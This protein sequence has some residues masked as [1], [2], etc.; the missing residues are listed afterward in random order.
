MT[1]Q[2][3]YMIQFSTGMDIAL[4][5]DLH[6]PTCR[7]HHLHLFC[8][9]VGDMRDPSHSHSLPTP[10]LSYSPKEMPHFSAH[11]DKDNKPFD[12]PGVLFL[13]LRVW[14]PD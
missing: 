9:K 7:F 14:G 1:Q 5:T 11:F 3:S 4:F 8:N 13:V 2:T 10:D 6:A 12:W